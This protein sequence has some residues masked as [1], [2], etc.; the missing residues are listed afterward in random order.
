MEINFNDVLI[1]NK[2]KKLNLVLKEEITVLSG[3]KIKEIIPKLLMG[4]EK[5][6]EGEIVFLDSK[7]D[8]R[9]D[10]FEYFQSK[11]GYVFLN[12]KDFLANKTIKEEIA[13]GLKYYGF[14]NV[15]DRVNYYLK[16]VDLDESY[17]ANKSLEVELN[18][19]KKV[20]LA[21]VLAIE[22]KVLILN[23]IEHGLNIKEQKHLKKLLID[24]KKKNNIMIIIISN[25]SNFYFDIC[26]RQIIFDDKK[27]IF[28]DSNYLFYKKN[29]E[30]V[31][32]IPP[33]I[34]FIKSVAS[35]KIELTKTTDIKELM[36]DI[37]RKVNEKR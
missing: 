7:I 32:D 6:K 18:I 26:E 12:P 29:I 23:F 25:D 33:I 13:F 37:Y 15:D 27:I 31:I 10:D 5:I 3:S 20:M 4:F 34:S 1:N 21:S 22:P 2:Y 16:L 11:I 14:K 28:D 8:S 17:L 9:T 36:K 35:K 30:K 19:Q 24:L